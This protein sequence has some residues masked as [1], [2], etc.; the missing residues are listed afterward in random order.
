METQKKDRLLPMSIAAAA[1]IIAGAWIYSVGLAAGTRTTTDYARARVE[2]NAGQSASNPRASSSLTIPW[3]G[4]G[5]K[6]I[7]AGVL[8]KTKYQISD[9]GRAGDTLVI[10]EKNSRE[11]LNLLW[12]FG[13]A[14]K[15]RILEEG[16]MMDPRYGGADRFASTGGWTIAKGDPMNHYARHEFVPLTAAQQALVERVAKNVYR[17]CCNNSTYFP[18][19]NHGMAM[20]GLLELLAAR[21]ATEDELY[22]AALAANRLWFTDEYATIGKF[23]GQRGLTF[24]TADPKQILGFGYSSATGY[25]SILSQVRTLPVPSG[26]G[27]SCG[28]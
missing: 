21:G 7:D 1:F 16:P 8:D 3:N 14:N 24:E 11:A 23:L 12:A 10:T 18:D 26:R 6:L 15:N 25:Q 5:Q 20:L 22:R 28:A 2:G 9:E 19:C 4:M 13:L 27:A 17:P